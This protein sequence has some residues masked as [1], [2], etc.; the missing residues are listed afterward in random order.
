MRFR[1]LLVFVAILCA[2]AAHA[3]SAPQTLI[4]ETDGWRAH[5][6]DDPAWA[7]PTFDDSSWTA[8]NLSRNGYPPALL[9]GYSRWF[10]KRI[11]L[12]Q[13]SGPLDLVVTSYD[14][15]YEVYIDGR[16]VGPPIQSSLSWRSEVTRLFP[17]RAA[18]SSAQAVEVAIRSHLYNQPFVYAGPPSAVALATSG[19]ASL[20]KTASDGAVLGSSIFGLVVNSIL[21][22]AGSLL[23]TLYLRQRGHREYLWLGLSVIFLGLSGG[24][25][26]AQYYI[27]VSWNGFLG[28]PCTYW[29][30]AAEIEFIYAFIGRR[31]HRGV[32]LYEWV[33]V[34]LPIFCNPFAWNGALSPG[35]FVWVENGAILPGMILQLALLIVWGL[36]GNREAGL[37]I[38]PMFLA[39]VGGF[40]FDIDVA[41]SYYHPGYSGLPII[42]L[43][44]VA[45]T[46]WP[47][48]SALFLLAVG[49]VIF[50]RFISVSQ[51]QVR[52]QSELESARAV[53]H[54]LIP[55]A[56][57][58]VPGFRI[59]SVYHPAQQ[60]GGDFFQVIPLAGGGVLAVVGDVSG[61]GIPAAL[62]V[63]LIVGTLR[64]LTETTT[65]PAEIL[66]GLNRRLTGRSAGFTTCLAVRIQPGGDA[67]LASAGHLNPYLHSRDAVPREIS[68]ALG[69]P[70]G[71]SADSEYV[72][73]PLSMRPGETLT[74]LSDGVVEARNASGELFGFDRARN[75]S[76]QPA[77]EIAHAAESFGQEDDI[78]VLTVTLS[79][80]ET[81]PA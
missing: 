6:G 49:L 22:I 46:V 2:L 34:L 38:G 30:I 70:L 12:P 26:M 54:V 14:K 72:D 27:P 61:K 60:V 67:A 15:S 80:R 52:M 23:I 1:G 50:L 58:D 66:A 62:T 8:V 25:I 28:D 59:E 3:Q 64:T 51:E 29:T 11:V 71:L 37:L 21:V 41:I 81:V 45:L 78:T 16:R 42:R 18:D 35:S 79:A 43:G 5:I 17:L 68:P 73:V 76:S 33:L 75:L 40:I 7:S 57:E 10:R 39:T 53:Q 4:S 13:Q 48:A 31:P 47:A 63:A 20:A 32:R 44:L 24:V 55:E 9:A 74:V 65:S 69:L 19:A 56:I 77:D 36:R